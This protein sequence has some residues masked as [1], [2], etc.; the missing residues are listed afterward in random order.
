M[1]ALGDRFELGPRLAHPEIWVQQPTRTQG[2][3]LSTHVAKLDT[4]ATGCTTPFIGG[5]EAQSR[6][7]TALFEGIQLIWGLVS[8]CTKAACRVVHRA[9][10]VALAKVALLR[11][12]RG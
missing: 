5:P 10:P 4:E 9:W 8:A 12:T 11:P 7:E 1:A 6:R 2:S 3:V